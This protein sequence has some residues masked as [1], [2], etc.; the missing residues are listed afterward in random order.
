M[1]ERALLFRGQ[2]DFMEIIIKGPTGVKLAKFAFKMND[3]KE[4][5]K[6]FSLL[7]EKFGFEVDY[8]EIKRISQSMLEMDSEFLEY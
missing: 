8:K 1:K 7:K 3:R 2:S 5:S 6:I 4:A